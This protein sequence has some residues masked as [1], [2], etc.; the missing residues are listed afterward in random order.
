MSISLIQK[1]MCA[2][3][4]ESDTIRPPE[5]IT[6]DN[7]ALWPVVV[8]VVVPASCGGTK[9]QGVPPSQTESVAVF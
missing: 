6:E 5:L 3:S 9:L 8:A 2:T 7:T 4:A 1:T